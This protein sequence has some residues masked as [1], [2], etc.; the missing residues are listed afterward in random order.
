LL[1]QLG[2]AGGF[3]PVTSKPCDPVASFSLTRCGLSVGS[4]W[5]DSGGKCPRRRPLDDDNRWPDDLQLDTE[6]THSH[7][8]VLSEVCC[9]GP[10]IYPS[11]SGSE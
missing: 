3:P 6:E 4:G 7:R 5:H 8:Q 1:G 10:K 11:S 2:L 9:S